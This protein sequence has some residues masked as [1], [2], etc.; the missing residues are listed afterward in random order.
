MTRH[1]GLD[2]ADFAA[3]YRQLHGRD[4]HRWQQR[5]ARA[6]PRVRSGTRCQH[7]RVPARR[8]SSTAFCLRWR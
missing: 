8:R 3:F 2:A 4:P 1:G 7:P 5:A 6:S